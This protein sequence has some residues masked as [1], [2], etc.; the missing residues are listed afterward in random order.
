MDQAANEGELPSARPLRSPRG[1]TSEPDRPRRSSDVSPDQLVVVPGTLP[2][3]AALDALAEHLVDLW[4]R[5]REAGQSRP[6]PWLAASEAAPD[7]TT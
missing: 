7:V 3:D 6:R 4:L 2:L 5:R 1:R